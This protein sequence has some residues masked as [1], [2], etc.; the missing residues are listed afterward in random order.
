VPV[1]GVRIALD[2]F[3]TGYSSLSFLGRLPLDIVKVPRPF[4]VALGSN[5]REEALASAVVALG[6]QL[7][8]TTVAEGVETE[9]QRELLVE[10]GCDLAQGFLFAPALEEAEL[11]DVLSRGVADRTRRRLRIA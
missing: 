8:L 5:A 4:V 7:Q 11:A 3:G 6:R 9:P 10:M 1:S 2:D